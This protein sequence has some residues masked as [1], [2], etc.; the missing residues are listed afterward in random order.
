M[1][2]LRFQNGAQRTGLLLSC[3][4]ALQCTVVG[5]APVNPAFRYVTCGSAFKIR[6]ENSGTRLHSHNVKYG[7]SGGGSGQQSVTGSM[8][9]YDDNSLWKVS[10]PSG[11]TC[12]PGTRIACG[13]RIRLQH[14]N[15]KRMLYSQ[16]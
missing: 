11:E 10:G 1:A 14:M 2:S 12:L 13:S 3:L 7:T 16:G 6:H 4:A 8:S 9:E 5:K 15:T